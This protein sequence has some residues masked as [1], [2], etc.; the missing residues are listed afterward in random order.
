[1]RLAAAGWKHGR[2]QQARL[3]IAG[4]IGLEVIDYSQTALRQ[5]Q[6]VL[7]LTLSNSALASF[8]D[9]RTRGRSLETSVTF[10]ENS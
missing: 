6:R 9:R 8:C 3:R 7:E 5:L 4:F 10:L 1:M 2:F